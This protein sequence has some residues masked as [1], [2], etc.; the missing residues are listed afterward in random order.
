MATSGTIIT[1]TTS[2]AIIQEALELLGALGEGEYA[3]DQQLESLRRTLNAL[4]VAWQAAGLNLFAVT[5]VNIFLVPGQVSYTFPG[6]ISAE[7]YEQGRTVSASA[8]S[9]SLITLDFSP[10][11]TVGPNS[12]IAVIDVAGDLKYYPVAAINGAGVTT[13]LPLTTDIAAGATAFVFDHIQ[14]DRFMKAVHG[15]YQAPDGHS[16]PM[17][18]LSR[19]EY[20]AL[21]RKDSQGVPLQFYVDP[22]P[23][24]QEVFIWPTATHADQ[25]VCLDVQRQLDTSISVYD[26]IEYPA[27]WFFPLAT[28]LAYAS[29]AKYGLPRADTMRL[30][31][32]ADTYYEMAEGFDF[33]WGTSITF[34]PETR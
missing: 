2:A 15:L 34:E 10:T 8:T 21:S 27:E 16:I 11:L 14:Q 1:T 25:V 3:N 6:T 24:T 31:D 28:G 4:A 17:K 7:R 19:D 12:Y 9:T 18:Q 30:K 20:E 5:S 13:T 23:L 32:L 22:Q 26:D 33:E 29:S